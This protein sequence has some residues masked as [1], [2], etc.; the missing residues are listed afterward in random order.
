MTYIKKYFLFL[1]LISA[2]INCSA[3]NFFSWN[4]ELNTLRLKLDDSHGYRN[5]DGTMKDPSITILEPVPNGKR[6][7]VCHNYAI[8]RI[9]GLKG[10]VHETL[11]ICGWHDWYA[12][13]NFLNDYCQKITNP[14]KG[15][16]AVYYNSRFDSTILHSAIVYDPEKDL[17]EDKWVYRKDVLI[18]PTYH[19]P[20]SYGNY[21]E[22]YRVIKSPDEVIQDM[23]RKIAAI[24]QDDTY[25]KLLNTQT[26]HKN[27]NQFLLDFADEKITFTWRGFTDNDAIDLML[28]THM[29]MNTDTIDKKKQT[30]LI[31][32]SKHNNTALARIFINYGA[33]INHQDA[34]GNTALITAS[35]NNNQEMMQLLWQRK[36][37]NKKLRNNMGRK[38]SYYEYQ[39]TPPPAPYFVR[40]MAKPT[41]NA[42][43]DFW[44]TMNS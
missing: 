17:V 6:Y 12:E 13:F 43:L 3:M 8:S 30:P 9:L 1:Y 4:T 34:Q 24:P 41:K 31:L 14:Q 16:L 7:G 11:P 42:E 36:E 44:R 32:T 40:R 5:A 20:T 27:S 39:H 29:H 10:S 37:C 33:N 15:D 35:K 18:H 38:A 28:E 22:Y 25:G 23:K 26:D 21:V 2:S 19:I